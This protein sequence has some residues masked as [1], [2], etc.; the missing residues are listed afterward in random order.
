MHSNDL[1]LIC[2]KIEATFISWIIYVFVEYIHVEGCRTEFSYSFPWILLWKF[3][4]KS[5][6]IPQCSMLWTHC[7][8]FLAARELETKQKNP[9]VQRKW[10]LS[11]FALRDFISRLWPLQVPFVSC[12]MNKIHAEIKRV[13]FFCGLKNWKQPGFAYF[14]SHIYFPLPFVHRSPPLLSSSLPRSAAILWTIWPNYD[15]AAADWHSSVLPNISDEVKW[16]FS[17][18]RLLLYF[19]SK[20]VTVIG[21]LVL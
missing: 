12:S 7:R 14:S 9:L 2:L 13:L 11:K 19:I 21:M 1:I 8:D 3:G 20:A 6:I 10:H 16:F 15:A 18:Y 5:H 4:N 17:D